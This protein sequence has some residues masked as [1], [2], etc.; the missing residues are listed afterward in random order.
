[1]G[2]TRIVSRESSDP[3]DERARASEEEF[4]SSYGWCLSPAPSLRELI[5]RMREEI[6][7]YRFLRLS[8]QREE[9]RINLYLFGCAVVCTTDDFLAGD[10]PE[11]SGLAR[12]WPRLRFAVSVL[13]HLLDAGLW[14]RNLFLHG[15]MSRWRRRWNRCLD[16]VCEIVACEP[17]AADERWDAWGRAARSLLD[18]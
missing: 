5:T 15:G 14:A 9:S 8:W 18:A 7:R 12:R 11:L 4:Y 10:R 6:D 2:F 17:G 16:T 1:M 13:R 3:S